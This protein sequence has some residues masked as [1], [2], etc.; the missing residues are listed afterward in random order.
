ML[1]TGLASTVASDAAGVIGYRDYVY[2]LM[3]RDKE[4]QWWTCRPIHISC[5]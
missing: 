4:F 3:E 5:R 1:E 2:E